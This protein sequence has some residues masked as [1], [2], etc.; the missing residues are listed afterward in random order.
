MKG[1]SCDVLEK[2]SIYEKPSQI[3]MVSMRDGTRLY[4]EVYLPAVKKL[5]SCRSFACPLS[6][7][8]SFLK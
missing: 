3:A 5:F 4:T 7:F 8:P 2:D 1:F 6:V